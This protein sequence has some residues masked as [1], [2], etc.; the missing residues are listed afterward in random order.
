MRLSALMFVGFGAILSAGCGGESG[1]VTPPETDNVVATVEVAAAGGPVVAGQTMQLSA[2]AR[3]A[4]GGSVAGKTFTWSSSSDAVA[5]VVAGGMLTGVSAGTATVTAS[6]DGKS[7][8]VTVTILPVPVASLTVEPGSPQVEVGKA[9][10]LTVTARDAAGNAL[11]GRPVTLVSSNAAVATVNAAM[12]MQGVSPGTSTITATAEGKTATATVTVVPVPIA[13]LTLEPGSP[14]VMVGKSVQMTVT[15]RDAAGTPLAGRQVALITSNTAVATVNAAMQVQ[16]VSP[17]TATITASAEGKTAVSLVTVVPV[18]VASVTVTPTP[19]TLE[20]GATQQLAAVLRD[21]DGNVLT[22]RT[23]SWSS[24]SAVLVQVSAAGVVTGIASGGPVTI[25]ATA[26]GKTGTA[27]V[28]VAPQKPG[29]I[30]VT[31]D[32][33]PHSS[34]SNAVVRLAGPDGL[35]RE[36]QMGTALS[37]LIDQLPAGPHTV[38]MLEVG[39]RPDPPLGPIF[40]YRAVNH[41]RVVT[42]PNGGQATT[43]FTFTLV[44]GA[45]A[46]QLSGVPAEYDGPVQCGVYWTGGASSFAYTTS[47]GPTAGSH[48]GPA[49]V[50]CGTFGFEG[51]L[52]DPSPQAQAITVPASTTP[53]TVSVT[54]TRRP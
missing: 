17:G 49:E 8:T 33:V 44:S 16:G 40:T 47:A 7:G 32:E 54:Y 27:Q 29:S 23:V 50:R 18:P 12:L 21:T 31:R 48:A 4:A 10:Q 37:L 39:S 34:L 3:N 43:H 15:A 41:N 11:A 42:V 1:G 26:E 53:I 14:Q 13:S 51:N 35:L 19:V 5:S 22:G 38:T 30:L 25:T 52:Y 24:G 45:V 36:R 20:F 2:V 46:I 28:T 6:A 9:V